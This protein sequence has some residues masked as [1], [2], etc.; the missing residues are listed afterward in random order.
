LITLL[1]RIIVRQRWQQKNG[2]LAWWETM[3]VT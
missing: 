2:A 3:A 1:K